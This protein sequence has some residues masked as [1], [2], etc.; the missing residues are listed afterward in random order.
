MQVVKKINNNV[1][2]CRDGKQRELIAFGKGIGFPPM[3][4]ELTDLNKIDRTFYNIG[5]QY[6]SLINELPMEVIEFTARQVDKE[7]SSLPYVLN[8]NLVFTLADHIAFCIERAKKKIFIQMPSV[9]EL[10]QSYPAE[11]EIGRHIRDAI[12]QKFKVKLPASEVQG[13]ALNIVNA[14]TLPEP[15][16][17]SKRDARL[18][19]Q[20]DEV[21]EQ[22]TRIV[23]QE[24]EIKVQRDSFNYAR[25]ATHLQYLLKRLY[26][27]Q[28]I[29]SDNI[30]MYQ[31][32]A[33]E[34]PKVAACVDKIDAYYQE[35]WGA[36]L[37]EEEKLYMIL[38]VNRVCTK[39]SV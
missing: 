11:V 25:F 30:Q 32:M 9:Y 21:L 22:T 29:D 38:H 16:A 5:S 7:C 37:T 14:K 12:E 8:P 33:E 27:N 23:E 28:P 10:E 24:M 19:E 31:S 26:D 6:L 13:I 2:I 18:Q 35:E 3:P 36:E 20:F 39:E 1:A 17:A 34:Y 4:Y 15:T